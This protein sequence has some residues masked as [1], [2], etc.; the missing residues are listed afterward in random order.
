VGPSWRRILEKQFR[1]LYDESTV[2]LCV[3]EGMR[4]ALGPHPHAEVLYP[5]PGSLRP[6]QDQTREK[7]AAKS[8]CKILYF[9]NLFHY[10]PLLK[11]A[12]EVLKNHP[13]IRLEV[14]GSKPNWPEEFKKEM[15]QHGLWLEFAPETEFADWAASGD[16][17][18]VPMAFEP[19]LRRQMETSFPSKLVECV[20]FE[21]PL[22]IWG[23][24][25]CSAI[26]WARR[27]NR[28]VCVTDPNPSA[29]CQ[30]LE[31]FIA[32]PLQ[33]ERCVSAS[34]TAQ[35]EFTPEK[36]QAQFMAALETALKPRPH[37]KIA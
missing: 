12:L 4:A 30:A 31:E 9:G 23:P 19:S 6:A 35:K 18:L 21:K 26:Q 17:F 25:Y 5:I 8:G 32:S 24:E 3:S 2:A 29:F 14:R 34:R 13:M 37:S 33:R 16:A 27:E 7:A 1:R 10:G 36:I 20:Q 28:A 11:S 15:S 22:V